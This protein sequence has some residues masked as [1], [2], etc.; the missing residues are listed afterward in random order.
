MILVADSGSTKTAW[1]AIEEPDKKFYF[2]S[3]GY[4][5]FF[6]SPEYVQE[7]L[8]KSFPSDF[9]PRSVSSVYFYGAGCQGDKIAIMQNTLKSIFTRTPEIAVEGDLLAA[10]RALL[11]HNAGF[12]AILG[13]G[14]N[15]CI[16]DGQRI[17]HNIDSLGFLL[18]DEGSGGFIG[19][20]ILTD[21][22]RGRMS[23]PI[24]E[25]FYDTY[26]LTPHELMSQAYASKLPNRYCA[27]FTRF[28]TM[29]G[30]DPAYKDEVVRKAFGLFFANLVSAYPNYD[31]YDLN[32]IGSIGYTFRDI[33]KEI[34]AGYGMNTGKIIPS[35]IT[36]LAA[37]HAG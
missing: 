5:P 11:G 17:T 19:K 7:S 34:A 3:E 14:T 18:G 33:L 21:F 23:A 20:L 27:G 22:I 29:E 9:D 31:R 4:N 8:N 35:L 26:Q 6:V 15:S 1:C 28:L 2:D 12:V 16:Y 32:C 30:T 24:R 25:L 13:T 36:D 10:A 37:Y